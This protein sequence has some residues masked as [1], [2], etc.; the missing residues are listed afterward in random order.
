MLE[1]KNIQS[2][3]YQLGQFFT[4]VPLVE[5]ILRQL[6]IEADVIVEPSFGGCGFVEPLV[7]FYPN[8]KIVGIELDTEWYDK[9]K[10]R[11]PDLDLYNKNFYDICTELKFDSNKVH[12]VGNV[13]FR[14][15]AFSLTTHKNYI[16][17][18]SHKYNVTGIRE[19]AVFFIIKTADILLTNQYQG[20]IHYIIPKSLITNNSKFFTQFKKFL[21]KNFTIV[22]VFDVDPSKFENVAQGLIML[23]MVIGGDES[24][25]ITKHNSRDEA[26]DSILQL[27]DADIPFQKIF[28]KTYLGSV[29][30]ESFLVSVS[31]E[32]KEE[33]KNRLVKI[34]TKTAT[35]ESL[36]EDLS[37]KGKY[38]LKVLS[39]NDIIKVESKL[40]QVAEYINEV[41][42]KVDVSIFKDISNYQSIQHRKEVRY[43]FRNKDVKKCSFV[44]ELN[45]NPCPSFYF[46]SN[47]SDGS[48]DY[49]GFCDY[50]ITRTSSPG[51]CRT[52]PLFE[53]DKNIHDSFKK[54]WIDNVGQDIPI[55]LIF[56]YIEYIS[57]TDWYRQQKKIRRRFYFCIPENFDKTWLEK[58]NAE[59]ELQQ[60]LTVLEK[61]TGS[62]SE[63]TKIVTLPKIKNE[64]KKVSSSVFNEFFA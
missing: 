33:F 47:P 16:K 40:A 23:S 53:V 48:T 46:T 22:N 43:Y 64:K 11:F 19:E 52:I 17:K 5:D 34:F 2:K 20:G 51:C 56:S 63:P 26:V 38:H 6:H 60:F 59:K 8:A 58:L 62:K 10:E 55:E 12:F 45:P 42:S 49:F 9:G 1:E 15:P 41:K 14:S 37:Y 50:D 29:P 4:P 61:D 24:N 13:P 35:I 54:Y 27:E 7:K 18:L 31:G 21:K 30:A 39:S 28:K 44:Y 25:Y 57:S 32:S 36:K 3:K